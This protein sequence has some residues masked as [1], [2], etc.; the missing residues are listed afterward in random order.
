V[1]LTADCVLRAFPNNPLWVTC[2]DSPDDLVNWDQCSQ[3]VGE[4]IGDELFF[5]IRKV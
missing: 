5:V 2:N 1:L 4:L 3:Q